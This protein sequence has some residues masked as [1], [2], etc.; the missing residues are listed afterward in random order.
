MRHKVHITFLNALNTVVTREETGF[1]RGSITIF[2]HKRNRSKSSDAII[3]RLTQASTFLLKIEKLELQLK[4]AIS[5]KA[6]SGKLKV[7]VEPG[8]SAG[9]LLED[10]D[11]EEVWLFAFATLK[12]VRKIALTCSE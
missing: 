10:A 1:P 6:S 2:T 9:T 7:L 5:S 11:E 3:S 4:H 12:C 8:C